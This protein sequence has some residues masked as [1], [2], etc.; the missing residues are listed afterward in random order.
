MDAGCVGVPAQAGARRGG[1]RRAA[2]ASWRRVRQRARRPTRPATS[3]LGD[4]V[5]DAKLAARLR[6]AVAIGAVTRSR[7]RSPPCSPAA[8]EAEAALGQRLARLAANFD[9]DGVR[10]LSLSLEGANEGARC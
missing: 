5:R 10:D 9:F 2:D 3:R 6:E 8:T 4:P 7:R 1:V